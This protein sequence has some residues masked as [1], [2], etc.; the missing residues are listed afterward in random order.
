MKVTFI[1][2]MIGALGTV[3]EGLLKRLEDLEIRGRVETI[4]VCEN[5]YLFNTIFFR[6]TNELRNYSLT[7]TTTKVFICIFEY[8]LFLVLQDSWCLGLLDV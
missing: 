2:I 3:T 4:A 5:G 6:H 8:G 7:H 1:S